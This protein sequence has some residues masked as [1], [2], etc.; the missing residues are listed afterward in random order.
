MNRQVYFRVDGNRTIGYG[1][2]V[3]CLALAEHISSHYTASF[4][5]RQINP[6]LADEVTRQG[7]EVI[8]LPSEKHFLDFL[9]PGDIVVLDGYHFDV[10]DQ[11]GIKCKGAKLVYIDDMNQGPFVADAVVNH[12]TGYKISDFKCEPYTRLYL[13]LKYALLRKPFL[14]K[15]CISSTVSAANNQPIPFVNFGGSDPE[16]LTI[17]TVNTL[18]SLGLKSM[19]VVVGGAY[20]FFDELCSYGKN[21]PINIYRSLSAEG[22]ADVMQAST[23][24]IVSA[25]TV[26]LELLALKRRAVTGYYVDNQTASLDSLSTGKFVINCGDM[27][28]DYP[29]KLAA[30][31]SN[32][33]ALDFLN[34]PLNISPVGDNVRGLLEIFI[35]LTN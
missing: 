28:K 19:N 32:E 27:L 8:H 12:G 4:F 35:N 23:F 16:N 10:N 25:S 2:V 5:C 21:N 15:A 6:D 11:K 7:I 17:S 18:L 22:M 34:T 24:G 3:R 29:K 1:H 14:G 20:Y 9:K 31:I 33:E 30:I 26:L 13:G